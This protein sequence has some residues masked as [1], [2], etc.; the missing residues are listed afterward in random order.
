MTSSKYHP[1]CRTSSLIH[2]ISLN[3]I[4]SSGFVL[5]TLSWIVVFS[6]PHTV[7]WL[8]SKCTSSHPCSLIRF[9]IRKEPND[10]NS[11]PGARDATELHKIWLPPMPLACKTNIIVIIL[12]PGMWVEGEQWTPFDFRMP[13]Y[14]PIRRQWAS[15]HQQTYIS[16]SVHYNKS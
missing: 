4:V 5:L 9:F 10:S 7:C 15:A 6:H 16:I 12:S 1:V 8:W 11:I 14:M 2:H 3:L 13:I